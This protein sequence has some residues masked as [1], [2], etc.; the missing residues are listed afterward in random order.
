MLR[1]S[2]AV[3]TDFPE[4]GHR[5]VL[6]LL[7]PGCVTTCLAGGGLQDTPLASPVEHIWPCTLGLLLGVGVLECYA[8]RCTSNN[9]WRLSCCLCKCLAFQWL[10]LAR[11]TRAGVGSIPFRTPHSLHPSF[12]R[13]AVPPLR[14]HETPVCFSQAD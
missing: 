9:A 8:M 10:L 1:P 7:Q 3:W 11:T 2:Q 12:P 4:Y 14:M 5:A 6:C 13:F